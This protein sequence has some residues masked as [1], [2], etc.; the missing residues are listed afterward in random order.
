[1][2]SLNKPPVTPDDPVTQQQL[3][4]NNDRQQQLLLDGFIR[5]EGMGASQAAHWS[6]I[7]GPGGAVIR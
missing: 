3:Q 6:R 5:P 4:V 1:V 2:P 7:Y